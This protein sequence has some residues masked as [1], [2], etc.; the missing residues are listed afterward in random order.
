MKAHMPYDGVQHKDPLGWYKSL[1]V[2][3]RTA[4]RKDPGLYMIGSLAAFV[5]VYAIYSIYNKMARDPCIMLPY[6]QSNPDR[7]N[8]PI[9]KLKNTNKLTLPFLVTED[10][11][12]G[13]KNRRDFA[14]I[15]EL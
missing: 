10:M 12:K 2:F 4:L 6:P 9:D 7:V 3:M 5:P 13:W 14:K 15:E 1:K 8:I 11:K